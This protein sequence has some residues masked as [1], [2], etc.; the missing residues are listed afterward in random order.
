MGCGDYPGKRYEDWTLDDPAG[1]RIDVFKSSLAKARRPRVPSHDQDRVIGPW[2]IR[3]LLGY[4]ACRPAL[5]PDR[6]FVARL[7]GM[8]I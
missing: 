2:L 7:Q 3:C 1:R 6:G 5:K 8:S 4:V